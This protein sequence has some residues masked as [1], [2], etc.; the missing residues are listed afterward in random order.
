MASEPASTAEAAAAPGLGHGHERC[1]AD[2]NAQ[3][4]GQRGLQLLHRRS[5]LSDVS[6]GADPGLLWTKAMKS[7]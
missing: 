6:Y 4:R 3:A 5:P 2:K 1:Q 7:P